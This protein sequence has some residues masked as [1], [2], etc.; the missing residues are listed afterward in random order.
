MWLVSIVVAILIVPFVYLLV[1]Y[2]SS[3]LK[4]EAMTL[5][6]AFSLGAAIDLL[7]EV[8]KIIKRRRNHYVQDNG[9]DDE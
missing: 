9:R 1:C 2:W 4:V 8:I 7:D 6:V 3:D 5:F